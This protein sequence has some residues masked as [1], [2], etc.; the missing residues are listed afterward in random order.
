MAGAVHGRRQGARRA[1]PDPETA[2]EALK[3]HYAARGF[4]STYT[5]EADPS[6]PSAEW[7]C[8]RFGRMAQIY[9]LL[10]HE[11]TQAQRRNLRPLGTQPT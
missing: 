3:A 4:V 5:I 8:Q 1:R 7:Y 10:G 2:W 9:K 6:L 11:P